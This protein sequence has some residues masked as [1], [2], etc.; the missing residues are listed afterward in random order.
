MRLLVAASLFTLAAAAQELP[1]AVDL[2]QRIDQSYPWLNVVAFD[3][4][5]QGNTYFAG[6]ALSAIPAAVNIRAGPLGGTD[7]V[8]I[9]VDP[10]GQ[11]VYGAAIGGTGDEYIGRIKV[12]SA[13]NLYLF[14]T[15]NSADYPALS[16][17]GSGGSAVLLRLDASG[18]VIFNT[19]LSWAGAILTMALDPAGSAYIGGVPKPGELPTT[20]GA[21]RLSPE[22]S[23]GFVA[24]ID[25]AGRQVEAATYI[26][27]PVT[28]VVIRATGDVLFSMGRRSR[29]WMAPFPV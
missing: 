20:P 22:G 8:V 2:V 6:S 16:S 24:R 14:G 27:E 26:E 11:L 19:R 18:A 15:T 5:A 4:D 21:Y 12:D 23:G 7:I 28:N 29:A 3:L 25:R 1:Q 17:Q 10:T 13:Q 9:K